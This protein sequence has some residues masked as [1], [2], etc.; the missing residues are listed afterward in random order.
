MTIVYWWSQLLHHPSTVSSAFF[1]KVNISSISPNNFELNTFITFSYNRVNARQA[2][3]TNMT[4]IVVP[5]VLIL[6][7]SAL[8][9]TSL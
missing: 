5:T 3:I 7:F 8:F 9:R 4:T 1:N 2:K 6:T